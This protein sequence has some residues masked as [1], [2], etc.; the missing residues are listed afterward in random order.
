MHKYLLITTA[1]KFSN[2][3]LL[4]TKEL[5]CQSEHKN[6]LMHNIKY[7]RVYEVRFS[8]Q[9]KCRKLLETLFPVSIIRTITMYWISLYPCSMA[10]LYELLK[11]LQYMYIV[12]LYPCS[13]ACLYELFK[14]LQ[15]MYI[16]SLYP[17]CI[18]CHHPH[19]Q[20]YRY[21]LVT[22]HMTVYITIQY[23]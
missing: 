20:M 22:R 19:M 16:V 23:A 18:A 10:C 11:P 9:L 21:N 4:K 7:F 1:L 5:M 15:Y 13:M 8:C 17:C 14:P 6:N 12:S 3:Q 2:N